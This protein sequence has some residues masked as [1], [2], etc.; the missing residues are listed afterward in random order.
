VRSGGDDIGIF[1]RRGADAGSDKTRNVSH[2]DHEIAADLVTNLA[3]A[4]IVK[5][6]AVG[7]GASHNDLGAVQ[8]SVLLETVVVD[9]AGLKVATVW[10]RFKVGR[11][12]GN[13]WVD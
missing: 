6:S 10:K 7:A 13:S 2:I 1:E 3:E 5:V 11:C 9:Q 8:H 4:G 12:D